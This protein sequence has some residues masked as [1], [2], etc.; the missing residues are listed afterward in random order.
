MPWVFV[1]LT[2][3]MGSLQPLEI[4][5]DLVDL[6]TQFIEFGPYRR[7]DGIGG[8]VASCGGCLCLLFCGDSLGLF[9]QFGEFIIEVGRLFKTVGSQWRF[10]GCLLRRAYCL[11]R[12]FS[13]LSCQSTPE[14]VKGCTESGS[15]NII[16]QAPKGL[17]KNPALTV[18][19]A[20]LAAPA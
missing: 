9:I 11:G 15:A 10:H 13:A 4:A 2:G 14:P 3:V 18:D 7:V 16:K 5:S 19:H 6:P 20:A 17:F 8:A 1:L 12:A